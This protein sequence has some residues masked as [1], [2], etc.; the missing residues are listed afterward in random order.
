MKMRVNRSVNERVKSLML[1]TVEK[2]IRQNTMMLA[3]LVKT[4]KRTKK[5]GE[6]DYYLE[7]LVAYLINK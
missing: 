5:T 4:P 7:R 1:V 6:N 3:V 2:P